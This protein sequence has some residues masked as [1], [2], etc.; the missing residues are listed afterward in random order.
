ML[1]HGA[2]P[3]DGTPGPKSK[4]SCRRA[5]RAYFLWG[6]AHFRK[7]RILS[8]R[9]LAQFFSIGV[10]AQVRGEIVARRQYWA[11]TMG[12]ETTDDASIAMR[13]NIEQDI[14]QT[15]GVAHMAGNITDSEYARQTAEHEKNLGELLAKPT[16]QIYIYIY[17]HNQRL[18]PNPN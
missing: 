3:Q 7:H 18:R 12:A 16:P 9:D 15:W 1:S 8:W 2:N 17:Y 6:R 10:I 11:A 4:R 14:Q 13:L 5:I